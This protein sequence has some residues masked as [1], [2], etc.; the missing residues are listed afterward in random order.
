MRLLNAPSYTV[1]KIKIGRLEYNGKIQYDP[2][3][4]ELDKDDYVRVGEV[5]SSFTIDGIEFRHAMFTSIFY[6]MNVNTATMVYA[7]FDRKDLD[8]WKPPFEQL[9]LFPINNP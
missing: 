3:N 2:I 8:K 5:L 6:S 7:Y 1:S 9:E 4:V